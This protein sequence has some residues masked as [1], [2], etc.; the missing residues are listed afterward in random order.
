MTIRNLDKMFAPRSIA[1]IGAS[2]R[3]GSVGNVVLKNLTGGGYGGKIWAVNR[4]AAAVGGPMRELGAAFPV[5][6]LPPAPT[7]KPRPP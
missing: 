2:M 7:D 6:G 5:G 1:L 4:R 3:A